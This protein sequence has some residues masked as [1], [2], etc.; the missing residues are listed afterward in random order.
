MFL[1]EAIN[2]DIKQSM[3]IVNLSGKVCSNNLKR[4]FIKRTNIYFLKYLKNPKIFVV[5]CMTIGKRNSDEK[6][7]FE[8]HIYVCVWK[9]H[10]DIVVKTSYFSSIIYIY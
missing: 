10:I 1:I 7:K 3:H 2:Y 5:K 9:I 4:Y 6:K 8:T